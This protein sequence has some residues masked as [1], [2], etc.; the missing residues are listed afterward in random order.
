VTVVVPCRNEARHIGRVIDSVLRS[1]YPRER[2]EALFVD[3]MSTDGTRR[4]LA[5]AAARHPF[6]RVLDNPR[7]IAPAA[8][9][10]G[11]RRARG[12]IIV[13]FDGHSL[14]PSDYIPR[15]VDLLRRTP[16]AALAGGPVVTVPDGRRPWAR[17][18]A[19]VTR[20][21]LGVGASRFRIG[22]D[23]ARFVD[24]LPCGAYDRRALEA[25]GLFDERLTRNQ[26]NELTSRLRRAGYTI[27]MDPGVRFRYFN[28]GTLRGL[29]RQGFHTGRWNVYT[30]L[31]HPYT[32]K[33]RHFAP[34]AFVAYLASLAAAAALL[35]ARA[36]PA[37]LPL[38]LYAGL[39]AAVSAAAGPAG[40]G[41]LRVAATVVSYH[42]SYGLGT[43]LGVADA[44]TGRWRGRLGRPL[45][46]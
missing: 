17:A 37:A 24:T 21:P 18:V 11:I 5:E 29:A 23:R 6:I 9:N 20:H 19:V 46:P 16:G 2:L 14:Y 42:L 33:P 34:G 7:L 45:R 10:E 30:A 13:R 8:L 27:A 38:A 26:D 12:E 36:A 15:C 43:H 22:T 32:F 3:G 35:G 25:V 31:L 39:V 28:Q 1:R 4:I 41:R 44:V 40:G